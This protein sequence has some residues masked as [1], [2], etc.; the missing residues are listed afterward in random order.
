M[1]PTYTDP[2]KAHVQ[3]P[4]ID[5]GAISERY[6]GAMTVVSPIPSPAMNRLFSISRSIQGGGKRTYPA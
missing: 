1:I 3:S 5:F 2:A 4:R 6:T